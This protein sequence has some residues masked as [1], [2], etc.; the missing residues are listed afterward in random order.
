MRR[1]RRGPQGHTARCFNSRTHEGCDRGRILR[2]RARYSFNSRTHEG[3]DYATSY[4]DVLF[5]KFQFTHPRGVRQISEMSCL[6][7]SLFQFTHPRGVRREG[8]DTE[9]ILPRVS[10]HAP[11]RGATCSNYLLYHIFIR[12]NSRTHEGCDAA[13]PLGAPAP[14]CFNSR[15]HEGCDCPARCGVS[16]RD[17]FNSRTHE[18]CDRD[19]QIF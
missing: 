16:P 8:G 7:S 4:G 17:R 18:G 2:L 1:P 13:R 6:S 19:V 10:I 14:H 12:F 15:T 3:C 5:S 9:R 11:T